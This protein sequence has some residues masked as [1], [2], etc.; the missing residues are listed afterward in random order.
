ML[1]AGKSAATEALACGTPLV[2]S[3]KGAI[4]E[5]APTAILIDGDATTPAY[6]AESLSAVVGLLDDCL[7]QRRRYR[8]LVADGRAHAGAGAPPARGLVPA[9]SSC[10]CAAPASCSNGGRRG[11][12]AAR[13]SARAPRAAGASVGIV[14]GTR[15]AGPVASVGS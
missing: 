6:Q 3:Y 4:P 14:A 15:S 13:N 12:L 5:T 11:R 7:H 10:A 8:D 2:A 1:T 9:G